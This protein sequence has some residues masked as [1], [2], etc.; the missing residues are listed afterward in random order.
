[1]GVSVSFIHL[2]GVRSYYCCW[3][4]ELSS[5]FFFYVF[6]VFALLLLILHLKTNLIGEFTINVTAEQSVTNLWHK[7]L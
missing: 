2:V 1:M 7:L 4:L 3:K 6:V 5:W